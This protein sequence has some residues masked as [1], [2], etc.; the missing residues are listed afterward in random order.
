MLFDKDK[1][2]KIDAPELPSEDEFVAAIS[3]KKLPTS[4][5][6]LELTDAE[7]AALPAPV[8]VAAP[9]ASAVVAGGRHAQLPAARIRRAV[10]ATRRRPL[11][12]A[13]AGASGRMGRM[14]VEAVL[15]AP[16]CALAGALDVPGS[17]RWARTPAPSWAAPPAWPS[18]RPRRARSPPARC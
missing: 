3:R 2:R 16:D 1:V 4:T 10:S 8:A 9:A 5:P 6:K 18:R 13:I 15:D 17:P 14:L 12:I 7:N 11:R